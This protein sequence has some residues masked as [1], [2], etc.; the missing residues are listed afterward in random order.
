MSIQPVS[1]SSKSRADRAKLILNGV[2][3]R[4]GN[5]ADAVQALEPVDLV[6]ENG[7]FVC[8]VGPSGCGK[9]TLL[10][11]VAG[12]ETPSSGSAILDGKKILAPGAERGVVFQQGALFNWM[13]VRD[14]VA[15]GPQAMGKSREASLSVAARYLELVGLTSFSHR[16]PYELSGGMQQRVAIA[17]ALANEPEIL[18]MDE[19]FAALDYQTRELLQE[20][21]HSIWKRTA[22]TVLW[23]THSIDEALVLAT[24]IVVMSARPGRIKATFESDFSKNTDPMLTTTVEFADAKRQI[25]ALLRQESI[26]AQRQEINL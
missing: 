24:H 13:T 3:K 22:S 1:M 5:G 12:F 4:F 18:L 17:R 9:S 25:V 10:S 23:I 15:F 2:S 19:P 26:E 14:N 6:V 16:Y 7:D 21:I 20:E 8:I 11:I